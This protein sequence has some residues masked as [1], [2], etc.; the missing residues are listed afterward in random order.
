MIG[1]REQGLALLPRV[2]N[3]GQLVPRQHRQLRQGPVQ[4]LGRREGRAGDHGQDAEAPLVVPG[5][6][7]RREKA[8]PDHLIGVVRRPTAVEGEARQLRAGHADRSHTQAIGD[9]SV[10]QYD[11]RPGRAR[12]GQGKAQDVVEMALVGLGA[13][14]RERKAHARS[15]FMPESISDR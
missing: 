14:R 12:K 6:R 9:R 8:R 4:V 5:D 10:F 2:G 11:R 13:R 1:F 7:G 3:A 15:R